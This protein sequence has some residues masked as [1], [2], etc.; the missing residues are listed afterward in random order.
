MRQTIIRSRSARWTLVAWCVASAAAAEDRTAPGNAYADSHPRIV[1]RSG[2]DGYH[3]FRIPALVRAAGGDLL[4]FAE[5]R[6]T[7]A[8]DAGDIDLVLKRSRDDGRTWGPLALVQ[9]EWNDPAATVTI[10]NPAPVVDALDPTHPGRVWLAF[11]RNNDAVFVVFSDDH[12]ASWSPRREITP[13]AK[14]PSW[15]WYATGPGHALQ[16][17]HGAARGRL[18]IPA[19]HRDRT[20]GGWGAHL[21]VSDDHGGTWRLAAIDSRRPDDA[22]LPN[23]NMAVE[24]PT[25]RLYVQARNQSKANPG[26]RLAATSSDGGD[27]FDA[28][29]VTIED[30]AS[31]IVQNSLLALP[32]PVSA[33]GAEEPGAPP[34]TVIIHAGPCH[35]SERRDLALRTSA[36]GGLTWS[37]PRIVAPGPAAYS[38]LAPLGTSRFGVLWEAGAALYEEIRF[39]EFDLENTSP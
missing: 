5:G 4:A 16:L 13:T 24:L 2:Q 12:G 37:A 23:E 11:C 32:R 25:G 7:S 10:G 22:V 26:H 28:P 20:T 38:D 31:P 1:F 39:Q 30:F 18:V 36:D 17:A 6:K 33:R 27:S 9:D 15:S 3:T 19:D 21:L 29:F 35:A 14:R 8:R 34:A